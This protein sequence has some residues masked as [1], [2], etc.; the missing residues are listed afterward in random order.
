MNLIYN[1]SI[2]TEKHAGKIFAEWI[3]I[4]HS[5]VEAWKL[6]SKH[7]MKLLYKVLIDLLVRYDMR[8]KMHLGRHIR[9]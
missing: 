6:H 4:V 8:R 7:N 1:H 3:L 2:V 9:S 5:E